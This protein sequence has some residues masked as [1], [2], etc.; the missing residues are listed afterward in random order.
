M[1]VVHWSLEGRDAKGQLWIIILDTYPFII[2]RGDNS[3][4]LLAKPGVSR[5]HALIETIKSELFISDLNSTNGTLLNDRVLKEKKRFLEGDKISICE[6]SFKLSRVK[7]DIGSEKTIITSS[8]NSADEFVQKYNLTARESELLSYL[9]KG[10][11]TK[12]IAD[13]MFISAGTAKNHVLN[14]LKKTGT[15]SRLE[16]ITLYKELI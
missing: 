1:D 2:G 9:I 14:L 4:L 7:D 5:Q 3:N 11:S 6:Y 8:S 16:L 10:I 15:H 12:E 13:S